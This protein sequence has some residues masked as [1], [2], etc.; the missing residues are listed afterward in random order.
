M[1]LLRLADKEEIDA[2]TRGYP[3][4]SDFTFVN[5]WSWNASTLVCLHNGNLVLRFADYLT[6]DPFYMFLGQSRPIETACALLER[7]DEEGLGP[8]LALVPE[9][10]AARLGSGVLT[11]RNNPDQRDYITDI[12]ALAECSGRRWH[13]QRNFVRRFER[14][15]P[16]ARFSALDLTDRGVRSEILQVFEEWCEAKGTGAD[17]REHERE[18]LERCIASFG[19][20]LLACGLYCADRLIGFAI[21]E[22]VCNGF[23]IDCFEKADRWSHIGALQ[24]LQWHMAGFLRERGF[25]YLNIEQDLGLPGL[26]R[27]KQARHPISYLNKYEVCLVRDRHVRAGRRAIAADVPF[28]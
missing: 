24:A 15:C 17:D 19:S 4:Y 26:R 5:L 2:L 25:R 6:G 27:G 8:R 18:A 20:E 10:T 14:D 11:V 21:M 22:P 23:A 9:C 1:R 12:H 28:P 13:R 16:R 3:P 7:S